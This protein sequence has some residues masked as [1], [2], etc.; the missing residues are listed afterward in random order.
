MGGVFLALQHENPC[1][2]L[3]RTGLGR[4]GLR[5]QIALGG[6]PD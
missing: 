4:V 1:P 6:P 3:A 2:I 5:N